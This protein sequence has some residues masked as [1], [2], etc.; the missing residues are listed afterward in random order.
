MY[1]SR[2][3]PKVQAPGPEEASQ[4]E[5]DVMVF[6]PGDSLV[7]GQV[8]SWIMTLQKLEGV[9]SNKRFMKNKR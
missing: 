3:P 4:V 6:H 8:G 7:A 2:Q 1:T 5:M 9:Y